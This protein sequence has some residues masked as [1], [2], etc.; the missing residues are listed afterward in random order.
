MCKRI[1]TCIGTR[2]ELVKLAPIIK[3]LSN[4]P[5]NFESFV[6][7]TGQHGQL[8]A[9]T[10]AVFDI[11]PDIDL[12]LMQPN[13]GLGSF[14]S[15]ALSSLESVLADT[16]P[17]MVLV[18]GDTSTVFCASL[19]AFYQQIPVG[20]VEAGLRT[21][22]KYV[23]FP[24]E[25]NR[26]LTTRLADLHF[27][28]TETARQSLL[29][30]GVN[31]ETV[32]LTGNT[33]IDALYWMRTRLKNLR[34]NLPAEFLKQLAGRQMVLI[35]GHRRENFGEGFQQICAGISA[36]AEKHPDVLFVYPVHLNPQVSEIVTS[37]LG[38]ISN[39]FL[40]DPLDYTD[41][42]W[43]MDRAYLV[44]TDSGGVQEEAPSLGKPVLVMRDVTERPEG[45][46][47]GVARL[48]GADKERILK[49]VDELLTHPQ[50]YASMAC[51][52]NPY[53]DGLAAARI[54]EILRSW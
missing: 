9:Q 47:A 50:V 49:N 51:V 44:L 43:L 48:V 37:L 5:E 38:N 33:V 15:R 11:K 27:A 2:P 10:A 45:V 40:L 21:N 52:N 34:P 53:G 18:Q 30:E 41:F 22:D 35:T 54:V 28:P 13:Q 31:P 46:T 8:L 26:R 1:L 4:D 19:A 23:P 32:Y 42:I 3:L 6:C 36:A 7:F 16:T 39:V 12:H 25:M 20:H 14:V 29:Q 24:E 17:D